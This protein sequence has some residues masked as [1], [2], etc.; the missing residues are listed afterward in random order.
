MWHGP[1]RAKSD[2]VVVGGVTVRG[3]HLRNLKSTQTK[4]D[5]DNAKDIPCLT[6][7]K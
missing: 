2:L 7:S 1:N 3:R 5:N 6:K 4:N